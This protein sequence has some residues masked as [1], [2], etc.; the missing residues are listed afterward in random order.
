MAT[1]DTDNSLAGDSRRGEH[2]IYEPPAIV[3]L[4]TLADLTEGSDFSATDDPGIGYG[5]S[6]PGVY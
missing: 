4:G 6:T 5:G 2:G 3:A 1:M